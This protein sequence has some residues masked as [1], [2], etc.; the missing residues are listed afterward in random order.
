[1]AKSDASAAPLTPG[2]YFSRILWDTPSGG[3]VSFLSLPSSAFVSLEDLLEEEGL[4]GFDA[5]D[6]SYAA[7][8]RLSDLYG[9]CVL[10]AVVEAVGVPS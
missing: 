1:M 3:K 10:G 5:E 4:D 8:N 9:W 2:F 6:L 7:T